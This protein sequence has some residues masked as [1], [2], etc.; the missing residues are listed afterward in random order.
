MRRRY[1]LTI[2]SRS[3]RGRR[4]K[5]LANGRPA[6]RKKLVRNNIMTTQ[7][8]MERKENFDDFHPNL[9]SSSKKLTRFL[10]DSYSSIR[11]ENFLNHEK[12]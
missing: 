1:Y 3:R 2:I 5:G 6:G 9:G 11:A 10:L 8:E 12:Q 4:G 7:I